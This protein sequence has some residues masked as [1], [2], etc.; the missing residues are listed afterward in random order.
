MSDLIRD[1]VFGQFLRTVS[2]GKLLPF[3]EARDTSLWKQ[4]IS[5][6]KSNR[7]AHH[8]HTGVETPEEQHERQERLTSSNET[9]RTQLGDYSEPKN[10]AGTAIDQEKGRDVHV[11]DWYGD[12]DPEV[13]IKKIYTG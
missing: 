12:D 13:G 3:P 11:V 7:M 5:F 10:L 6:E 8:G 4:Y 9:S 2:G 1:T